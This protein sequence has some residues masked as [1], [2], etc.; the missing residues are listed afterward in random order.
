MKKVNLIK[1]F[2]I[3]C[4]SCMLLPCMAGTHNGYAYVDLGLPSGLKW[5]TCNVGAVN[6]WDYG[7]YFALGETK[8][9][10]VYNWY[11]YLDGR[12]TSSSDCGTSKDLFKGK[13]G[14]EATQYDA[15]RANMGGSWRMP[16]SAETKEL[17]SNCYW[18]WT[19]N[20]NG[21]GVKGYIVYKVK[22]AS[23][24]GK[25]KKNGGTVTTVGSYSLSDKHIFLPAAGARLKSA[26]SNVGISGHYWSSSIDTDLPYGAYYLNFY[27]GSVR[28]DY[29]GGRYCGKSVRGVVK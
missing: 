5:A 2:L 7:S 17:I 6:S 23:D 26:L 24:K 14:V 3:W 1:I 16:T 29:Y 18:E 22:H 27:S 9:K 20:Y 25:V 13:M 8:Q 15:A 12:I 21:K 11:T 10:S 4:C 28:W 19:D